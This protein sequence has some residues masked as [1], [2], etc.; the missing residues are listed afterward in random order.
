MN[1]PISGCLSEHSSSQ[2]GMKSNI[3]NQITVPG[4]TG[5]AAVK[6]KT[7]LETASML[8]KEIPSSTTAIT[9]VLIDKLIIA[10]EEST[11]ILD[12]L[13]NKAGECPA[14]RVLTRQVN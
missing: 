14:D 7:A 5:I 4:R 2:Q 11:Q 9:R 6:V 1:V 3:D 8:R 10:L 13:Y 12:T